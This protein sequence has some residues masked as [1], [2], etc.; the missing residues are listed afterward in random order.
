MRLSKY[1][2]IKDV[3]LEGTLP[4]C[5]S[6]VLIVGHSGAGKTSV[7]RSLLGE[8]FEKDHVPTEGVS[9]GH[10]VCT[11]DVASGSVFNLDKAGKTKKNWKNGRPK[12]KQLLLGAYP[13]ELKEE[14]LRSL[15]QKCHT[16]LDPLLK[17]IGDILKAQS[18]AGQKSVGGCDVGHLNLW[19]FAGEHGYYM[20]HQ[21][22][23][24][25]EA[26]YL[27][28]MDGTKHL[29][30]VVQAR[31]SNYLKTGLPQTSGEF[32]DFWLNSIYTHNVERNEADSWEV[33]VIPVINQS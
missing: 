6:R 22:F 24:N 1:E 21:L 20:M 2:V 18:Q 4:L 3:L 31:H 28:V 23:L 5:R 15:F 16:D 7:K 9:T 27:L 30:K 11:V 19:D 13:G 17:H 10:D 33:K 26:I 32:A 14:V 8:A 29:D 25:K 12:F